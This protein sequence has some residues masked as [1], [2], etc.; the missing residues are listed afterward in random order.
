MNAPTLFRRARTLLAAATLAAAALPGQAGYVISDFSR[1]GT[2]QTSLF[3]IN[4]SGQMVGYT[5][6]GTGLASEFRAF[7]SDGS[8][9]TTLSGPAGARAS[10]A[11][12][13]S[14]GGA[15]VGS[16]SNELSLDVDGNLVFG[17]SMGYIYSGGSYES[18]NVAG[19]TQ[20]FLRGISPDGRYV[21]GY[22]ST[23]TIAGVG[24][25]FDRST[26]TLQTTSVADSVFTIMQG[27]NS[28][29]IAVGSDILSSTPPSRPGVLF[30][31]A[32][33]VRTEVNLAGAQRTV[34]RD[35]A[36]DGT[37]TG[38]FRDA[39]GDT[40]GFIGDLTD[41]EILAVSG[42]EL[43]FAEGSNAAGVVVGS[44]QVDGVFRAFIASP[45]AV[46]VPATLALVLLAAGLGAA[47]RRVSH[48]HRA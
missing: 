30:D 10:Y 31:I 18:F 27:I 34:L 9:F 43:T 16:Y 40:V 36:D 33:G 1:P 48:T 6:T 47:A 25:V 28:A 26:S 37:L 41:Y 32:S 42:A 12:G 3:D 23:T 46:P 11:L 29:G 13:I 19:A 4:N 39:A 7:V 35:I 45:G 15:V 2:D 20:T 5:V 8:S 24:F 21:S 17:P 44:Y 14:D 38:W 22:Y